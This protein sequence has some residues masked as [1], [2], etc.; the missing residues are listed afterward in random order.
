MT[1]I[2][3][4]YYERLIQTFSAQLN[5]QTNE[6]EDNCSKKLLSVALLDCLLGILDC[7]TTFFQQNQSDCRQWQNTLETMR[8]EVKSRWTIEEKYVLE[9]VEK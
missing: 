7:S 5:L 2:E 8:A 3:S 1:P 6:D 4:F 9:Q